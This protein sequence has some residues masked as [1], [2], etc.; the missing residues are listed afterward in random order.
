[1]R[2]RG[3]ELTYPRVVI[4]A[5]LLVTVTTVAGAA[6]TSSAAYGSY[7]YDRDGTSEIR[8]IAAD[9]GSDVEIVRDSAAY[10]RANAE[11]TTAFVLEPTETYSEAEAA[12]VA[13]F[14]G[15]GGTVVVATEGDGEAN[16]LL[17]ALGVGSR[18][19]GRPLR[20][21]QRFYRSPALPIGAPVRESSATSNVSGVTLNHGTAVNVSEGGT[22][23][24]NSSA[25]SYLDANA[26]GKLDP[27]EPTQERP[28][29]VREDVDVERP[30]PGVGIAHAGVVER[31]QEPRQERVPDVLVERGH[32]AV[33]DVSL[34]PAPHDHIGVA[35]DDLLQQ[36]WELLEVIRRV[37]VADDDVLAATAREGVPIGV[38]VSGFIGLDDDCAFFASDVRGTIRRVVTDDDFRAV[39]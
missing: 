24:V 36:P 28:I 9:G 5:V 11:S 3:Y 29:V 4:V 21:E 1:M 23:L 25:F 14:L 17:G 10:R 35:I 22:V 37:G 39:P 34:E 32:R 2:V 20:D 19:D 18:F 30:E 38:A 12:A 31:V 6:G 15:R 7:N 33:L 8:S 13:S 26:N 16:R 27:T